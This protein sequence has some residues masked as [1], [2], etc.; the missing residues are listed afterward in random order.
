MVSLGNNCS[1]LKVPY[2]QIAAVYFSFFFF[3]LS[4]FLT[5]TENSVLFWPLITFPHTL[6]SKHQILPQP[7]NFYSFGL[8]FFSYH[9][10]FVL[11][12]WNEEKAQLI[13]SK[14]PKENF[15]TFP[16]FEIT[17]WFEEKE[18]KVPP[19]KHCIHLKN[20]MEHFSL[21]N[22]VIFEKEVGSDFLPFLSKIVWK[23]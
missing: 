17:F 19:I 11:N 23:V 21:K 14:F 2:R 4:T 22:S 1:I 20:L 3:L 15:F 8:L 7:F 9:Y 6:H 16:Q 12:S 10:A 18:K 5:P 13:V